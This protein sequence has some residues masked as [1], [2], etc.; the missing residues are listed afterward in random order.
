VYR[1]GS[2]LKPETEPAT[3]PVRIWHLLTHTSGLTYGFHHTH[4]VDAMYRAAG[5]EWSSPPGMDLAACCDA[6]AGFPLL[7]QPGTEWNYGVSTDVL[8]R[9]V[10]V[11][12]GQSLD[13]FFDERIFRPLGMDQ[14]AFFV[15]GNDADRLA[16]LYMPDPASG[17]ATRLDL[18]GDLAFQRPSALSGGGGL[19]ST[20]ADYHR[21]T[22]M[23][24]NEGELD[25]V[26]LLGS[27][28]VEYMTENHLPGGADLEAVG[29][30]L[31][32]E[33]TFDGMGFG[34]GFSVLADPVKNKVLASPGEFAWGG[35]ASTAFWIDPIEQT[36]ALFFTQLLPSST[37]PIRSQLKQLV[38]QALVD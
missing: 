20:A 34:L 23:L 8:G 16:A 13:R 36:T 30:P 12:G 33:T 4:P 15:G 17:R 22:Q 27:R 10:E 28:T 19:V 2:A 38:Y 7:F 25:G 9:M 24:L 14:T 11:V 18:L 21:F 3:E 35:A 37:Y 5:F 26:R 1:Q 32:S 29:R 6:W 31:F